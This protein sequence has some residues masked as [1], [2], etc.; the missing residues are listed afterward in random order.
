MHKARVLHGANASDEGSESSNDGDETSKKNG[1]APVFFEELLGFVDVFL[2]DERYL[3][4]VDD[5]LSKK[6]T[7]PVVG[8]V[9]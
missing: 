8:R 7:N 4:V 2:V 6:V 9:A 5:F 3:G 1:F